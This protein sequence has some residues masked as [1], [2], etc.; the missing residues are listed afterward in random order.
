MG[1][2]VKTGSG[3]SDASTCQER[4]IYFWKPK[5]LEETRKDSSLGSLKRSIILPIP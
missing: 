1:G 2:S 4:T 3:W 5:K